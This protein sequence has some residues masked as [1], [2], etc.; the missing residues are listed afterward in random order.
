VSFDSFD[1]AFN[2]S[3]FAGVSARC[4]ACALVLKLFSNFLHHPRTLHSTLQC[5]VTFACT[6]RSLTRQVFDAPAWKLV[7]RLRA[8]LAQLSICLRSLRS[9]A[10]RSCTPKRLLV[11][12]SLSYAI[13]RVSQLLTCDRALCHV[14]ALRFLCRIGLALLLN[15]CAD[16]RST[17]VT[18]SH[19]TFRVFH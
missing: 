12:R 17:R 14:S 15:T 5:T 18:L 9:L 13:F 19:L 8:G 2:F 16:L 10:F 6:S 3:A 7:H 1:V 4:R 11:L